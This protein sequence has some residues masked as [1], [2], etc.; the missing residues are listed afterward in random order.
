M[1]INFVQFVFTVEVLRRRVK[2]Q[3]PIRFMC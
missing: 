1:Q 3:K 2:E